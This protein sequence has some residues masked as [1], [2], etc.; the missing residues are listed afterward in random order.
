MTI[1]LKTILLSSTD[2]DVKNMGL[3]VAAVAAKTEQKVLSQSADTQLFVAS[4]A[5]L[6]ASWFQKV[7][8][9]SFWDLFGD[10]FKDLRNQT[11]AFAA[12]WDLDAELRK[13]LG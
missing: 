1:N 2:K 6:M 12:N 7:K 5:Q 9:L 8:K 4:S 3:F 10:P 13:S 11:R